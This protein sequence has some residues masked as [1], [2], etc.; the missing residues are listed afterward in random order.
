MAQAEQT[1]MANTKKT[2]K[3]SFTRLEETVE[4]DGVAGPSITNL[5]HPHFHHGHSEPLHSLPEAMQPQTHS[6]E[7]PSTDT[8]R[9]DASLPDV[10]SKDLPA[11]F[12]LTYRIISN[13]TV[14]SEGDIDP[15]LARR[16]YAPTPSGPTK[17]SAN[18]DEPLR[19]LSGTLEPPHQYSVRR[20]SSD[21]AQKD[22]LKP[23]IS[24]LTEQPLYTPSERPP[25]DCGQGAASQLDIYEAI[26]I[27]VHTLPETLETPHQTSVGRSLTDPY[28]GDPGLAEVSGGAPAT[29]E[30]VSVTDSLASSLKSHNTA[31]AKGYISPIVT[32]HSP[33]STGAGP[34]EATINADGRLTES[35]QSLVSSIERSSGDPEKHCTGHPQSLEISQAPSATYSDV[36]LRDSLASG[37][38]SDATA[39]ASD[40]LPLLPPHVAPFPIADGSFVN[41]IGH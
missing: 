22:A 12:S 38:I 25:M 29:C 24:D 41:Q 4:S 5:T 11:T 17:A 2:S 6:I 40:Q 3:F 14:G 30:T 33:A 39:N 20:S 36:P 10:C 19:R 8:D 37:E 1:T 27:T 31:G 23:W 34:S 32:G 18:S 7:L 9:Q 35:H 15:T 26:N 28:Q 13:C 21:C 16:I